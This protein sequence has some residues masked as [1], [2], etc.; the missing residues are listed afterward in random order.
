MSQTSHTPEDPTSLNTPAH[1]SLDE[2]II[3]KKSI[4]AHIALWI[5]VVALLFL[6]YKAFAH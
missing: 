5:V 1:G 4:P 3:K 6:F 2:K